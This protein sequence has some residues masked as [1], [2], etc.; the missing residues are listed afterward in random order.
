MLRSVVREDYDRAEAI[1]YAAKRIRGYRYS[2]DR[3]TGDSLRAELRAE[4]RDWDSLF[5]V[6]VEDLERERAELASRHASER[7]QCEMR[8][9]TSVALDKMRKREQTL[10]VSKRFREAADVKERADAL[11][12]KLAVQTLMDRQ[13]DE[14]QE[15]EDRKQQG[16]A[17]IESERAKARR[18][19][20][21][22]AERTEKRQAGARKRSGPRKTYGTGWRERV[23]KNF[24]GL[25]L[26]RY[27]AEKRARTSVAPVRGRWT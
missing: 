7:D 5:S 18:R 23:F 21:R 13:R 25:A 8:W 1:N 15:F 9:G 11:Q 27:C 16:F 6:F 10:A 17:F 3:P 26:R 4:E 2:L 19:L 22:L 20:L 24:D 12:L 14:I